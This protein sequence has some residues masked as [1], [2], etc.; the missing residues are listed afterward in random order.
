MTT[1]KTLALAAAMASLPGLS[2]A[3]GC[4]YGKHETQAQSCISGTSWDAATQSC[5]PTA[6]S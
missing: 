2:F 4:N 6:N 3:M 5:V 1:F